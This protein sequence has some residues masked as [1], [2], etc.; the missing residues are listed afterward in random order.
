MP[1]DYRCTI[2]CAFC[3]KK[4]HYADNCYHKQRL[5]AKL[6]NENGDGKGSGKGNVH[7]T[8]A[9]AI[10]R[11]MARAKV[12]RPKVDEKALT[13]SRTGTRTRT[14]LE[15]IPILPQG[16]TLSPLV[17][18]QR[19]DLRPVPRRKPNKNKGLSVPTKMGIS[20]IAANVPVSCAWRGNCRTRGLK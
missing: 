4:K 5:S 2:T 16:G 18:H 6:N 9:R 14:S 11:A 7:W 17:G 1:D 12:G 19:R 3:G 8:V 13:A 10:L 15:G 20:Q